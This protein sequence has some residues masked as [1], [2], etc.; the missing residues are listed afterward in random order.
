MGRGGEGDLGGQGDRRSDFQG[1]LHQWLAMTSNT[2]PSVA[3]SS[4]RKKLKN[5]GGVGG[6]K[7][8]GTVWEDELAF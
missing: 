6:G 3:G 1:E 4:L 7:R 2:F 8:G 5:L